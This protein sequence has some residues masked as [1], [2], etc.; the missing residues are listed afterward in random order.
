MIISYQVKK[1]TFCTMYNDTKKK[2]IIFKNLMIRYTYVRE[3]S[4]DSMHD[5][6]YLIYIYNTEPITFIINYWNS[7]MDIPREQHNNN[8]N[9]FDC[10]NWGKLNIS[11][12]HIFLFWNLNLKDFKI[13]VFICQLIFSLCANER[14]CVPFWCTN[15][16][17]IVFL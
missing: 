4:H 2:M 11:W 3:L 10:L 6:W 16:K 17:V 14:I 8:N 12:Y 5:V 9:L 7:M 13:G 1:G 15:V